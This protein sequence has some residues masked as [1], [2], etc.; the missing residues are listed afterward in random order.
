MQTILR[1]HWGWNASDHWIVSDCDAVQQV[2]SS[3]AH[4]HE[5]AATREQTVADTLSAGTDLNCGTY[6]P[7]Y[8]GDAIAQ[9]LVQESALDQSL[10]RLYSALVRLGYFDS[11]SSHP[12]RS[13]DWS[14]VS[15]PASERL[16][17]NAAAESIVL[18][19]NDGTLPYA[20]TPSTSVALIGEW[21]NATVSMQG[22]YAGTA[23]YLHSPLY[24]LQQLNVTVNYAT[25][26]G[27]SNPLTDFIPAAINAANSSDV[28][29]YI[30]GM[31]QEDADEG[32]D[33]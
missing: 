25:G 8:L 12:Y 23:P 5:Y 21:A 9:G 11:N 18:L 3:G 4:D 29:I 26:P 33:R 31:D 10:I 6:Y 19:K 1:E 22:N 2:F 14:N 13:L 15:T 17:Y 20:I 7:N 27:Q 24:A 32:D 16:A 30:G 28:I